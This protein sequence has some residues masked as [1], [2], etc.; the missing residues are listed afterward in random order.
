[1]AERGER[2]SKITLMMEEFDRIRENERLPLPLPKINK[3]TNSS[4]QGS[5][6]SRPITYELLS[7]LKSGCFI[8]EPNR[9]EETKK[10]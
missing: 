3:S 2:D 9:L 5:F 6:D 8:P 10:W 1:M 7:F 4:L